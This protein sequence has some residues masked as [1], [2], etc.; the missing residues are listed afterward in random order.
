LIDFEIKG[1]AMLNQIYAITLKELQVI[2]HDLGALVGLFLMPIAFI[3]V[4]TT[5]LQGVFSAG[6]SQNPV[7]LM[8]VNQ[9]TGQIADK[10]ITDLKGVDG[11]NIVDQLNGQPLT[12]SAAEDLIV[13]RKYSIAVVFPANFSHQV[14]AS[15]LDIHAAASTVSFVIDPTLGSELLSPARGMVQGFIDREASIAQAPEKTQAGLDQMAASLPA[16]QKPILQAVGSAFLSTFPTGNSAEDTN[17][18]VAYEV[19]S[20]A[21]FQVEKI[22]S[23]AEQNVPGYTI[24]GVF[25]IIGTIA[26]SIFR[27]RNEGTFRRLQAAP[28]S[29]TAI[30]IGKLL[31]YYLINLLQIAV[32]FAVGVLVFHVGLG[33]DPL[34]LVLVSLAASAAATGMG[35]LLAA[36]GRT[37]EQVGSL[38]AL[39]SVVL[40]AVGGMMVPSSVMPHFMQTISRFTPHAWALSGFQDII[41]RGLGVMDI[42]PAVGMLLLFALFFWG[43]GIWRFRF[44]LTA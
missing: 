22:P 32:M 21:K 17:L 5:A 14:L 44:D 39:I 15:S 43:I 18:G 11:L 20:P 41:V 12:R 23:S 19:V 25:F 42:L 26:S 33:R 9:D 29:K 30:M 37:Q 34:A 36:L 2:L 10:I 16:S 24:Y 28:L 7:Q 1:A 40:A 6:S 3:L 38:G 8:I 31:P 35:F 13:A 4:M 27:E